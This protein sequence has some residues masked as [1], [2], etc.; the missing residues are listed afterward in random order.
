LA[1]AYDHVG[2]LAGRSTDP[3][4]ANTSWSSGDVL[5]IVVGT[6]PDKDGRIPDDVRSMVEALPE[7]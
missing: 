3:S 5:F 4:R 6:T 1:R 7:G 2:H